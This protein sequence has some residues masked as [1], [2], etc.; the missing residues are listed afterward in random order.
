MTD[1]RSKYDSPFGASVS[2]ALAEALQRSFRS[3]LGYSSLPALQPAGSER[4]HVWAG[5]DCIGGYEEAVY[6]LLSARMPSRS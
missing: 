3:A 6:S 2:V 5:V 1:R 4:R